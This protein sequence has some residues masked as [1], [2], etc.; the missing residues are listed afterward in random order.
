MSLE[1][2]AN[3]GEILGAAGVIASLIFVGW[4]IRTNTRVT[5]LKM[6]EQNAQSLF[7]F[8]NVALTDPTYFSLAVSSSEQDFADLT[9][10]QKVYL[11]A[12]NLGL[13]KNFELM[14]LQHRQGIMDRDSWE[15][16]SNYIRM[17]FHEPGTQ[18]WW[19]V[20]RTAFVPA[21]RDYLETSS[22]PEMKA[23]SE[24]FDS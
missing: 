7:A 6:Y 3:I 5:R 20:R 13:F 22:K 12:V 18:S 24:C 11:F 1:E 17:E 4:Q 9:D 10:E 2:F 14:F 21:F 8:L 23:L 15:A 19:A 16:W